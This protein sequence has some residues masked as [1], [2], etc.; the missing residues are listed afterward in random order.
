MPGDP[1]RR[2]CSPASCCRHSC[3]H[4]RGIPSTSPW[5]NRK[6][7]FLRRDRQQFV[8]VG[9]QNVPA[10]IRPLAGNH[11][12][13]F[14]DIREYLRPVEPPV[15]FQCA[16]HLVD[17]ERFEQIVHGV[18]PEGMDGVL[19]V[20]GREDHGRLDG[21]PPEY[22]ESRT[23][24]QMDVHEI[25]SG[26]GFFSSHATLCMTLSVVPAIRMSGADS[27]RMLLRSS[28]APISSSMISTLIA[29]ALCSS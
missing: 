8:L 21:R 27:A 5:S 19:V 28:R 22:L 14:L 12:I 18:D 26:T 17:G 11:F 24:G 3:C 29:Y 10:G 2:R 16:F 13:Q 20:G 7:D 23:V 25:R 15:F 9:H 4:R 6:G 1:C